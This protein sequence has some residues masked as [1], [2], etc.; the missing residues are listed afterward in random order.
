[1]LEISKECPESLKYDA[2]SKSRQLKSSSLKTINWRFTV[3]NLRK[4]GKS[5]FWQGFLHEWQ[6]CAQLA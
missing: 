2:I 6:G 3:I 5:H 4:P 1:M